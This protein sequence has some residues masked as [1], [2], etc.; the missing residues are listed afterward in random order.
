ME[1]GENISSYILSRFGED[2]LEKY[3]DY[4]KSDFTSFVRF[5]KF[6]DNSKIISDLTKYGIQIEPVENIPFAYKVLVGAKKIGKTLEFNLGK[7]YIQ[8]LSSMLPPIVLN[9]TETDRTLDLCAAPGSKTTQLAD[10]MKNSGTLIANEISMDRIK[11]LV[12]NLDK[13]NFTNFGVLHTKGELL[14]KNFY[15]YFDKVLVDAPCSALGI[16]QKKNEVSGWW[17]LSQ[18]EK[19]ADLQTRLLVSGIKMAKVGGE[20]VY[21][22]C[23]LTLEENELV[24]NTILKNYPVELMEISLPIK[25]NSG[26]TKYGNEHLNPEIEKT[27]RIIPWESNSEGFF[28]CKFRKFDE[29]EKPT[30]V[31]RTSSEL[32]FKSHKDKNVSKYLVNLAK[33]FDIAYPVF[34]NFKYLVKNTDIYFVSEN[35]DIENIEMFLRV[36]AKFGSIDKNDKVNLHTLA[37]Q[38]LGNQIRRNLIELAQEEMEIYLGGGII[39]NKDFGAFGQKIVRFNDMVVGTAVNFK[40]GLKSQF[41]RSHRTQNIIL[42]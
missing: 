41:P 5:S 4:V 24:V 10:F 26:F 37:S 27:H 16:I 31:D 34:E 21:S 32:R 18:A 12:H 23:T 2:Y 40:E 25:S 6:T 30:K 1:L 19:L 14:S 36:G 9:P 8:S 35:Y 22:T 20:I 29:T 39:R 3:K 33:E 15:Q 11:M 13:M 42:E 17:K 38:I 7:Y 28:V